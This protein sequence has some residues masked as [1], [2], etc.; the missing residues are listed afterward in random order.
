MRKERRSVG[1]GAPFL[2]PFLAVGIDDNGEDRSVV[3]IRTV[4]PSRSGVFVTLLQVAD[5]VRA[6][7]LRYHPE[8]L[9]I[10]LR[11]QPEAVQIDLASAEGGVSFRTA[12]LPSLTP[13]PAPLAIGNRPRQPLPI[14][15]RP[16]GKPA[17]RSW[18]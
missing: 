17:C 13:A 9:A 5:D 10:E 2:T 15:S 4:N 14:L 3:R 8:T 16:A 1:V 7:K 18:K 12:A 11:A 6:V